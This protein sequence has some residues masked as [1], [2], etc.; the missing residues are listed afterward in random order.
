[1]IVNNVF[2]IPIVK[3]DVDKSITDN[4][5]RLVKQFMKDTK[6]TEPAAPGELLTT[7]Y[8]NKNFLG[9][10]GD[11]DLLQFINKHSREYLKMLGYDPTCY[12]EVTSWLQVNQPLSFFNRHDHYGALISGVLYLEV[13]EGAGDIMF[14]NPLECR[15]LSNTFFERIKQEEN[16]YNFSH[17]KVTSTVG[18]MLMFESWLQHTVVQNHSNQN[19]ISVAFNIWADR[20]VKS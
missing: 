14:H 11:H 4:T 5:T 7:F 20:D 15:R 8:D 3:F 12:I 6:F 13:P 18:E 16:E 10:L 17:V 1:M 19:R 2:P 9:I